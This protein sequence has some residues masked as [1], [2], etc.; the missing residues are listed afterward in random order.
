MNHGG[1]GGGPL[2]Q[3]EELRKRARQLEAEVDGKLVSYNRISVSQNGE[4]AASSLSGELE[5]LL[6]QLSEVN[7]QM[8]HCVRDIGPGDGQRLSHVLQRHRELLH[9][10]DKE[11]R[12]I[13]SNI[14]EQLEREDLLH[15]VRQ[16]IGEYR[17]AATSR[18]DPLLRERGA[19]TNSLR[20]ADQIMQG[21]ATTL[22]ALKGQRQLYSSIAVKL[23]TFTSKLP[24]IDS[25]IGKVQRRKK[26]ESIILAMVVAVCACTIIY[27]AVLR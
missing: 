17:T 5:T 4:A 26:V 9:D 25:L 1:G 7:E 20:G 12:K 27:F 15:S 21:A 23:S 2:Q 14:K 13:K 8:G 11:F 6:L 10:Y 3:W 16:D 24:S 19:A 18:M 22:E